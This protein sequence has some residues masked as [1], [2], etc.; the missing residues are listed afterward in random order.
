MNMLKAYEQT[1]RTTAS[2]KQALLILYDHAI[3]NLAR[4]EHIVINNQGRGAYKHFLKTQEIITGLAN[5]LSYE[6]KLKE[7]SSRLFTLYEYMMVKL[8]RVNL[9]GGDAS[10]LAEVRGML[11]ELREAWERADDRPQ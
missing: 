4:C 8:S 11:E 9:E 7:I 3:A 5:G 2:P 1:N 6:G 10:I